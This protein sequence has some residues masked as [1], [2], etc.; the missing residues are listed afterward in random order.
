M[1]EVL[2]NTNSK[3]DKTIL[4]LKNV[5][6]L[7]PIPRVMQEALKM[8]EGKNFNNTELGKI[9]SRD[10]SLVTKILSIANSPMYGLQ[11]RVT[12]IDFAILVLGYSELKNI[13]SILSM[14]EAFKNKTDKYL[15]QKAFWLHSFL[16]GS[17]AKRLSE[18][19]EFY[20]KGEAFVAG[21]LHDIGLSVM[22]RYFHSN[23]IE[24]ME[25]VNKGELNFNEAEIEVMGMDHQ[26][27]GSYLLEHWN[28]P[29]EIC[30]AVRHH[31]NPS[32]ASQD[33]KILSVVINLADYMS[34]KL[35]LGSL[36]FDIDNEID[37]EVYSTFGLKNKEE[38]DGFV[39]SYREL[40]ENQIESVK[41]LN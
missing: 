8:I 28:F 15:D 21:F 34:Q 26:E 7:P 13:I 17:A 19:I 24:I 27:I 11:R 29:M 35:Q 12:S 3:K 5:V 39:E 22:H 20:N 41:Y 31:H 10:L 25:K 18:E 4:V 6:S 33:D 1:Q 30:N 37:D 23:F 38:L 32:D 9:I 16:I 40:F 2:N 14:S 36:N